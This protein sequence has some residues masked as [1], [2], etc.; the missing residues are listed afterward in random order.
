MSAHRLFRFLSLYFFTVCKSSRNAIH[1]AELSSSMS[2]LQR[3][4]AVRDF[5]RQKL[6]VLVSTDIA[7]R[8]MDMPN[9][10][11]V[12]NFDVPVH[13]KTYLH[14]IG[15]TARAGHKGSGCTILVQHQAHHFRRILREIDRK[16]TKCK[17]IWKEMNDNDVEWSHLRER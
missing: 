4:N 12:I 8:G 11:H 2:R 17:L 1:I 6:Q 15:R 3:R 9:I 7:A 16:V 5:L 14:R 10:E 13:I